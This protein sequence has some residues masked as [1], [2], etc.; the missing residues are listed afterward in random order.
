[1]KPLGQ[2]VLKRLG[3]RPELFRRRPIRQLLE[4]G[5]VGFA[6]GCEA[7]GCVVVVCRFDGAVSWHSLC[8]AFLY[9][10]VAGKMFILRDGRL[11]DR[12]I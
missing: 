10:L 9:V 8:L 5:E 7:I 11:V 3:I 2:V 6:F 1:M 12:F 4:R